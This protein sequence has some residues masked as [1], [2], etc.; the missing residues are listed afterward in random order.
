MEE[1]AIY[2]CKF[3]YIKGEDNTV[4]DSLS[5]YPFPTVMECAEAEKTSH[6]PC[7]VVKGCIALVRV[8]ARAE[9]PL[10][11]VAAL[12]SAPEPENIKQVIID[13][14]LVKEM[15]EAYA[16]DLWC[17]QLLSA[18]RGMPE[19]RVKDGLWFI[20]ERLVIPGGCS[21]REDIFRIAHDT[22]GH[23]GFYK[24][25]GSLRGSY[26]WPNMRKDLESG[27]IP[28]C[29][30]CQHNKN[31]MT[32]PTG[33]LHPLLVPDERGDSVAIDFI[34]PLPKENRFDCLITMTDR[35]NSD[36]QL[37]PCMTTTTAEQLATLFFDKWYCE[38]GLL[39]EVISD[40][41]KL[42]MAK[43]WK[44]LMLITGIKH[45][46]SSAYH[47]QTDGASEHTNKTINQLIRFYV[48]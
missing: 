8:L 14:T 47:P 2:D 29:V 5:R 39:L 6:H 17:R 43:F 15:R 27:Y 26:F 32:K 34:G 46:A 9:S 16:K 38:N 45:H 44:H 12:S 40:R 37:V 23:F 24:T 13:D 18:A 41:D 30:D 7:E 35:L 20:G 3:V 31:S 25:Y 4:A 22:L 28:S 21:A 10:N 33:P 11:S 1:L 48:E 19:V 36:V 42:F